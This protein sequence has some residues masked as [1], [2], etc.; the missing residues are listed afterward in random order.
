MFATIA[1]ALVGAATFAARADEPRPQE[2]DRVRLAEAFRLRDALAEQLWPGWS[3]TGFAV[4]LVTPEREF[5]V[6]HPRPSG[7]FSRAGSDEQ[8]G[9]AIWHRPRQFATNLLATFPAVGG[10]PTVVVGQAENTGA[11][12]STRWVLTLL[13]E[14][15]HQLQDSQPGIYEEIAR[16]DLARGDETGMWMLNF[17]FPYDS[18]AVQQ[19]YA[20]AAR[21]LAAALAAPAEELPARVAEYRRERERFR[22]AV[23][24]ADYRYF[25]FQAWKEG[26]ARY[27]EYRIARLAAESYQ[28]T[29]TFRALDDFREFAEVAAAFER[30]IR[31]DLESGDLG[32]QKRIAFYSYGAAEALLLDRVRPDWRREYFARKFFLEAYYPE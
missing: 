27:T 5:L 17:P 15:F 18:P 30:R 3:A 10:T 31:T 1:L 4:L 2:R 8:L 12:G 9:G 23:N 6:R 20:R 26:V 16:L 24:D 29:A 11:P 21:A 13:H 25:S 32:G 19:R 14:H 22:A 28:P 7:D